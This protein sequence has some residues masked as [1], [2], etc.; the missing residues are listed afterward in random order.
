MKNF[1]YAVVIALQLL[2]IIWIAIFI[3]EIIGIVNFLVE[4]NQIEG[5][6]PHAATILS[7]K[8][9]VAMSGYLPT[10]I[11][12]IGLLISWFTLTKNTKLP[13]WYIS[14][15]RYLSILWLFYFPLGTLVGYFQLRQIQRLRA[16]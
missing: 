10:L 3:Q 1:L 15:N 2:Y 8:I 5:P 12:F 4:L 9:S 16:K 13:R 6:K 14:I 11:A 7:Q